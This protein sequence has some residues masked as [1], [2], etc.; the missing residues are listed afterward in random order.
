MENV[1]IG[2]YTL[3]R[4]REEWFIKPKIVD[5]EN[6]ISVS[7]CICDEI[8][9]D[10]I[11][12]WQ[13]NH[14]S[15]TEGYNKSVLKLTESR[16]NELIKTMNDYY[17]KNKFGAGGFFTDLESARKI[18]NEYLS[19]IE[20]V[21]LIGIG[22][23]IHEYEIFKSEENLENGT[24]EYY[25]INKC[26][27]NRLIMDTSNII[28]Y[29]ILGFEYG[30]FHSF[31]CNGLERDF[32]DQLGIKPKK[33]GLYNTYEEVVQAV[34]LIEEGKVVGEPVLWQPWIICE[35]ALKNKRDKKPSNN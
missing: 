7:S 20:D 6:I 23:D 5:F 30:G 32:C 29:D 16:L 8:I 31:L 4:P 35:Y 3:I 18:Y 25:A 10:W 9:G 11:L 1:I 14:K 26:L 2:G 21:R 22:L 33:N 24:E 27:K 17:N 28:G 13:T 34:D 15:T 19:H 12:E